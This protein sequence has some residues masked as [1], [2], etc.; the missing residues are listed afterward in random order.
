VSAAALPLSFVARLQRGLEGVYRVDTRLDV[1]AFMVGEDQRQE[2]LGPGGGRRPR[3]QLLVSQSGQEVL[4]GLFLDEAAIANLE[5][6]DPASGLCEE[7]FTD[8]LLAV[9][10]VSHFIYVALCAARDRPVTALELELQAEV[11]KFVS[12]TLLQGQRD[13]GPLRER[14]Y[15]RT[16]LASD[17]DD[18]ERAR[19]QTANDEARRYARSLA[20]RY[21]SRGHLHGM[22]GELRLFYRLSL[23]GKLNHIAH[24]AA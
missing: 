15:D 16:S 3:E 12:C 13:T 6:N 18:T 17:L 2:A 14:L 4:L 5:Q 7:N 24:A 22:L 8:F 21:V 1:Q 10:G 20:Q 11:D 19:Y 23:P 9:E